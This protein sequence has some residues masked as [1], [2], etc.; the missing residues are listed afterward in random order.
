MAGAI[1]ASLKG[2]KAGRPWETLVGYT[3]AD[4]VSHLE[5]MFLPGMT[6]ENYGRGGWVVDHKIPKSV[7]NYSSADH[8]DF[9]R[10]W[11][12]E[13]LQPLW[14]RDNLVKAAK[15]E[16]PFQPSLSL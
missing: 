7:F 13:N 15:I 16:K 2:A 8:H 12:L 3:L 9:L 14:E 5:S 11:S 6:W 4:L 1:G 10:C